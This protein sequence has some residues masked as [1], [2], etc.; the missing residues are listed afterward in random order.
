MLFKKLLLRCFLGDP[1]GYHDPG[2]DPMSCPAITTPNVDQ[3]LY[4]KL[5]AQATAA[6]VKFDGTKA[7][8]DGVQ[9]D[10]NYDAAAQ[11]LTVTCLEKPWYMSCGEIQKVIAEL[12][13]K[14]QT[15]V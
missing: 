11:A 1:L 7:S 15:G 8:I 5:L 3:A 2:N 13:H 12:I 6:G 4:D 10:W 14:A 9:L